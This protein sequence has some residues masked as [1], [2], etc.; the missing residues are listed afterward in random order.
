VRANELFLM[1]QNRPLRSLHHD[2]GWTPELIAQQAI[3][4]LRSSFYPLDRSA[5]VFSWDPV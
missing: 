5:D 3:P 4:A 1:S 2:G